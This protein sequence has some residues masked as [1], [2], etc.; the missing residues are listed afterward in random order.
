MRAYRKI[1]KEHIV[2]TAV[3]A[4]LL[5]VSWPHQT[6]AKI[7]KQHLGL[8]NVSPFHNIHTDYHSAREWTAWIYLEGRPEDIQKL[9]SEQHFMHGK[10]QTIESPNRARFV[11][12]PPP[13]TA[14]QAKFYHRSR[15]GIIDYAFTGPD[16]TQLW[17][18]A[19][20]F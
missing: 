19:Q 6:T 4:C 5:V 9:L 20:K 3:L 18:V 13:P 16:G 15:S 12:A 7:L 1:T 11:K 2:I 10:G 17:L 8:T 14:A